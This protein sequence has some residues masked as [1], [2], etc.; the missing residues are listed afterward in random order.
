MRVEGD[1]AMDCA[2][3]TVCAVAH[4]KVLATLQGVASRR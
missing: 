1:W 3:V 2:E 4:E